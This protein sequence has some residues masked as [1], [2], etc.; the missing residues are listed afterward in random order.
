MPEAGK[1]K[2]KLQLSLEAE[3]YCRPDAPV[4]AR[5]MAAGGALPLAAPELATVLFVL[6]HDADAEV[7]TTARESLEGLPAAMRDPVLSGPTHPAVLSYLARVHVDDAEACEKLALNA[8]CDDSTIEFLATCPHRRV[9]DIICNNQQR[10]LRH[11]GIVDALGDNRLTGRAQVDRILSFLGLERSDS[12]MP[13]PTDSVDDWPDPEAI[14]DEAAQVALSSMLGDDVADF[15]T[16]LI[17]DEEEELGEADRGNLYKRIGTMSV[18]QK[19]KLA[20]MGNKE[21]RGLLI[22]D[23]NKIVATAA[24]RSPRINDSEITTY[25]KSRNLCEEVIRAIASNRDWTKNYQVKLGLATNPK[26]PP[27]I[28]MKFLNH[29]QDRDLRQ[30]MKSKDVP[31]AVSSHARRLLTKKGKI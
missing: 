10:L 20:R 4:E 7:K 31:S 22:R 17:E 27:P 11:P 12:E 9:V 15:G 16:N 1:Q 13:E 30:I 18:M 5:R 2:I 24:I 14:T 26:C 28:A 21:A 19:I 23:K 8:A 29:L 3:K 6:C 25:A